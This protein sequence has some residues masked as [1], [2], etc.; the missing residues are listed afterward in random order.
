MKT[1][2]KNQLIAVII[3][4]GIGVSVNMIPGL[5][6]GQKMFVL[7]GCILLIPYVYKFLMKRKNTNG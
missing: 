3:G 5:T 6:N 2:T 1:K 4:T 7:F